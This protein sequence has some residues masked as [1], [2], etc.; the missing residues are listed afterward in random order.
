[1]DSCSEKETAGVVG[2]S[3]KWNQESVFCP[4]PVTIDAESLDQ[5]VE[6]FCMLCLHLPDGRHEYGFVDLLGGWV[7]PIVFLKERI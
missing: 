2:S 1:M 7:L 4:S 6:P 5:A 3:V